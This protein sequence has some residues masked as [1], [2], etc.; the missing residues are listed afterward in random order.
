[1]YDRPHPVPERAHLNSNYIRE[2]LIIIIV[3]LSK[4]TTHAI[5]LFYMNT[6]TLRPNPVRPG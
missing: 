5:W 4:R 3:L 1:M 2:S 6:A